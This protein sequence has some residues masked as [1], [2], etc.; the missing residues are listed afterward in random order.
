M[1]FKVLELGL[2]QYRLQYCAAQFSR[3]VSDM[4]LYVSKNMPNVLYRRVVDVWD[5]TAPKGPVLATHLAIYSETSGVPQPLLGSRTKI[6]T[7]ACA[8]VCSVAQGDCPLAT[9]VGVGHRNR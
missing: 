2:F 6:A 3:L 9:F 4:A 7:P 8:T 1:A 5:V